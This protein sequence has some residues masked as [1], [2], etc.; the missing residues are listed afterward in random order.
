MKKEIFVF[1]LGLG[2][3]IP[4]SAKIKA[5]ESLLPE[6]NDPFWLVMS[7]LDRPDDPTCVTKTEA[8]L[9]SNGIPNEG[10]RAQMTCDNIEMIITSMQ[11][12]MAGSGVETNLFTEDE[13]HNIEGLYFDKTNEGRI[14]FTNE[15]DFMSYDFMFFL[16]T[17]TERLSI[18]REEI[19][20]DAD[21]VNGLR[22]SGAILTMRNVS[23]FGE[24][25]IIVDEQE[26]KDGVVSALSYNKENKTITFNVA[27]F[28]KFK[29]IEKGSLGKKAKVYKVTAKKSKTLLGKEIIEVT[30]RG[31]KFDKK[32]KVKLGSQEAYKVKW[33]NKKKLVAYFKV[34]NLKTVEKS[35]YLK[36]INKNAEAEKYKKKLNWQNLQIQK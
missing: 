16:Q 14:E 11:A 13:W 15:I 17:L 35:A 25:E 27:H 20:L 12:G 4:G 5:N 9:A 8:L 33:K 36:V 31:S 2:I 10:E 6:A 28:T 22:N 7:Q 32:A 34:S 21:I 26:D 29:A 18:Q 23:D 3:L 24:V 30:I 1:L 19:E